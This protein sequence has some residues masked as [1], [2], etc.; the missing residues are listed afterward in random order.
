MKTPLSDNIK[1]MIV[2]NAEE[3]VEKIA[4][5]VDFVF[6]AVDMNKE[7]IKALE[8]KYAKAECPVISNNSANR[9]TDDVPMIIPEVNPEHMQIID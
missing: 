6:C 4:S 9:H 2:L 3:D 5:E 8:E 1:K 7:D